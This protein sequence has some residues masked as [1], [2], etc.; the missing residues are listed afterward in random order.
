MQIDT[1]EETRKPMIEYIEEANAYALQSNILKKIFSDHPNLEPLWSMLLDEG[2]YKVATSTLQPTVEKFSDLI[3]KCKEINALQLDLDY[4]NKLIKMV[5]RAKSK[6]K[7][8]NVDYVQ[9]I[10]HQ[11]HD[12]IEERNRVEDAGKEVNYFYKR[13]SHLSKVNVELAELKNKMLEKT[14][15]IMEAMKNHALSMV[16]RDKQVELAAASSALTQNTRHEAIVRELEAEKA[17]SE[18]RH[19]DY[20]NITNALSPVDGL[21]SEYIQK[22]FDSF[23]GMMNDII[24]DIWTYPMEILSCSVDS[25]DV[26]C[27]F[28]LSINNGYLI[29]DDISIGSSGQRDFID[30]VFRMVVGRYIGLSNFPLYLD[31]LAPTLDEQHRINI[32]RYINDLMETGN[33]TQMF[34]ISH[35]SANHFAFP[36][37]EYLVMDERNVI[38]KPS[39]YNEHVVFE[40]STHTEVV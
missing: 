9:T 31:E 28:P 14:H 37:S 5:D 25:N 20:Q 8:F 33:F 30:F 38:S 22:A 6:N 35:Y 23:I 11:I 21:I 27:K 17:K 16:A 7:D 24:A 10:M 18:K 13:M 15:L 29:S 26:T 3:N 34:Y 4:Q 40:Y 39:K 19:L 32:T 36:N 12:T 2:L 1:L